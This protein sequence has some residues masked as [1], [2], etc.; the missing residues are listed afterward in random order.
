M[1]RMFGLWRKKRT[2][3]Q[4]VAEYALIVALVA[5]ASIGIFKLFGNLFVFSPLLS[6]TYC[7]VPKLLL[8]VCTK[9]TSICFFHVHCIAHLEVYF[10]YFLAGL[11]FLFIFTSSFKQS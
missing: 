4:T 7:L 6:E 9:F 11:I 10:A 1:L 3:A 5:I 8:G 2:L